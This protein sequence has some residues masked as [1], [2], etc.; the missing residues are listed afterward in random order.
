MDQNASKIIAAKAQNLYLPLPLNKPPSEPSFLAVVPFA[1]A[2]VLATT[3][4]AG[5]DIVCAPSSLILILNPSDK[6]VIAKTET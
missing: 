1:V 4:A 2:V 5:A 6:L 3:A